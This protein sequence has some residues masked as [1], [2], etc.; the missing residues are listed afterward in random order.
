MFGKKKEKEEMKLREDGLTDYNVYVMSRQEKLANIIFAAVILFLVGYVFYR[1]WI[2][3]V[4]LMIFSVKFPEIRTKQIIEKRKNQ[5]TLQ[6][7]DMLYSLSSALSVG[8]S[9]ETGIRDSLQDLRVI[10]PDPNTD[11]LREMEYILR[12]I[13]MN[14]TVEEMFAQFG[15]RAHLEDI[16]NFVDIFVTCKRTGGDLIEVMRSTSNTIG[17]KIEVKQEINTMISGKKYEFNFMM[18]LPVIMVEF[19]ALTSGD[20][21]KPVFTTPEGIAAMTAAIAIFAV[22][23]VVGSKIM[24]IDI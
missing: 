8:K 16:D 7:K 1:N 11:I 10:Y 9:V 23:Y 12:G 5:L 17:E 22:A 24:K 15:E 14:N 6:F 21:M 18:I 3:S 2:L 13:G 4:I 20:Y 19:L